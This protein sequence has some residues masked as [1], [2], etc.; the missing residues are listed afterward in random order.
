MA[1][2]KDTDAEFNA[3]FLFFKCTECTLASRLLMASRNDGELDNL[4]SSRPLRSPSDLRLK[5]D[6]RSSSADK[7]LFADEEELQEEEVEEGEKA[8]FPSTDKDPTHVMQ[9]GT[10]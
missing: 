7:N 5:T 3:F 4:F 10:P 1:A 2:A 8:S 9:T 6:G